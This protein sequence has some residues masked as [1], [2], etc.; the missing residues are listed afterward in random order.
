MAVSRRDFLACGKSLLVAAALPMAC[1]KAAKAAGV[2]PLKT[3]NLAT[4]TIQ[5]FQPLVN[6]SFSVQGGP[7]PN[8]FLTLLSVQNMN[9]TSATS[10]NSPAVDTFAL[11]FGIT[12]TALEKA[13]TSFSILRWE[14]LSF[15]WSPWERP[16]TSP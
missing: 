11:H 5:N 9:G 6:S 2:G 15:S 8:I 10:A 12:G 4:A 3:L 16:N 14:P 1:V 7:E 13:L